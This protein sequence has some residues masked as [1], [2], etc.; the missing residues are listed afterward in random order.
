MTSKTVLIT[1]ASAGIGKA[2]AKQLIAKGYTVYAA[3][4]RLEKMD[5]LRELG[6]VPLRMDITNEDD[7]T[8][9]V[10]RIR[11]ERGGVDILINNAGF[12]TQG[13]IEETSL[14]DA[15]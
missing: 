10:D 9:S 14:E 12:G 7:I 3:A 8:S 5:D 6:C 13:S 11:E 1:G 4:R 2:T 15:R